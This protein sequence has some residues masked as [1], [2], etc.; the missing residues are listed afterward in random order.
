VGVS[1]H[2]YMCANQETYLCLH[3]NDHTMHVHIYAL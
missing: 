3:A 2:I 1:T